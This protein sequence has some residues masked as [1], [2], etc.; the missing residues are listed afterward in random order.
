MT[1]RSIACVYNSFDL[2][3]H[4]KGDLRDRLFYIRP[5]RPP[6]SDWL[7]V[8]LAGVLGRRRRAVLPQAPLASTL[9]RC[10]APRARPHST[11]RPAAWARPAHSFPARVAGPC[12]CPALTTWLSGLPPNF[13]RSPHGEVVGMQGRGQT[14]VQGAVGRS[15]PLLKAGKKLLGKPPAAPA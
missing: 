1:W 7:T 10:P 9:P 5:C 6:L 8:A 14:H 4:G 13:H 3:P 15:A 12:V 11:Q 2:C